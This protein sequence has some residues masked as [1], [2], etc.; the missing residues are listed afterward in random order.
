MDAL[1]ATKT[2][3][4]VNWD[5]PFRYVASMMAIATVAGVWSGEGPLA[6]LATATGLFRWDVAERWLRDTD[7]WA[8]ET[9]PPAAW[10]FALVLPLCV[11]VNTTSTD[12][13][14]ES[15][16]SSTVWLAVAALVYCPPQ[17]AA[18]WITAGVVGVLTRLALATRGRRWTDV[19]TWAGKSI[20]DVVAAGVWVPLSVSLWA[21]TPE[22]LR[23]VG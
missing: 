6:N 15:R 22:R 9:L 7:A 12:V 8:L 11:L 4:D 13:V 14:A 21:A 16:A 2:L 1:S 18:W 5:L 20:I 23:K 3:R 10:V 19:G 17:S